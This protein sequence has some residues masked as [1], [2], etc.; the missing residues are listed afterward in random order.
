M[1]PSMLP[2]STGVAGSGVAQFA[3]VID[4]TEAGVGREHCQCPAADAS[5]SV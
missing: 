1:R 4:R 3:V 5:A 2:P